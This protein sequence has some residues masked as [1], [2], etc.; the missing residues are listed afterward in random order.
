MKENT[1][2]SDEK[3]FNFLRALRESG[4]C[5]MLASPNYLVEEYGFTFEEAVGK[6]Q[7]WADTL[8]RKED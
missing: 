8:N 3:V 7:A 4:V 1:L 6:F 2:P 5:N